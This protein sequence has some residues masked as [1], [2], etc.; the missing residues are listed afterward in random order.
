ME[1]IDGVTLQAL[2]DNGWTNDQI[3]NDPK[4]AP[5][6]EKS[7]NEQ[8]IADEEESIDLSMTSNFSKTLDEAYDEIDQAIRVEEEKKKTM[9]SSGKPEDYR[10]PS[11]DEIKDHVDPGWRTAKNNIPI[12]V[13]FKKNSIQ[14][15]YTVGAT[16]Q[17]DKIIAS[18]KSLR[19]MH[20]RSY[21]IPIDKPEM[22]SDSRN[23]KMFSDIADLLDV[24]FVKDGIACVVPLRHNITINDGQRLCVLSKEVY[25]L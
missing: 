19:M 6:L 1:S 25:N 14:I 15:D 13:S 11:H 24:R 20:G 4:W 17:R 3:S 10:V 5:L 12:F 9:I 22:N 23:I 18:N 7:T 2:W 16:G 8:E 21:M